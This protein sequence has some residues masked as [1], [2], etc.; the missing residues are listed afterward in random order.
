MSV[1]EKPA[2]DPTT[3]ERQHRKRD[4]LRKHRRRRQLL[5]KDVTR[6][7]LIV[8]AFV[9]I[10]YLLKDVDVERFRDLIHPE[11]SLA[12]R[13][14]S[15]LAFIALA[16]ILQS[17]GFFRWIVCVAAGGLYGAAIGIVLAMIS[18]LIGAYGTYFIGSGLLRGV[19]NRRL[20]SKRVDKWRNLLRDHPFTGTLSMRLFPGSNA[21]MTGLICGTCRVNLKSYFLANFVGFLPQTL[22]FCI[23]GSAAT[24]SK[25]EQMILGIIILIIVL[26]AQW[27]AMRWMKKRRH[28]PKSPPFD[29]GQATLK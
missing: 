16:S 8:A 20:P 15:Y 22:I 21:V 2:P 27:F 17:V 11:A 13:L 10:G 29:P 1:R 9:L 5:I 7:L 4:E 14:K 26:I 25:F 19:V 18:S 12:G 23:F 6:V 28:A 24:K 3:A